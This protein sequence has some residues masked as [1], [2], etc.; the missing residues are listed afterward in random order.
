[1]KTRDKNIANIEAVA[2]GLGELLGDVTFVGGA[3]TTLYVD[4]PGAADARP[5]FDVDCVDRS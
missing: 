3:A 5:T 1:M 2:R 4:D